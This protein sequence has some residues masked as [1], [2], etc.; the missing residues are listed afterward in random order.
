MGM[1]VFIPEAFSFIHARVPV[2]VP[3]FLCPL[4][5]GP[6]SVCVCVCV[7]VHLGLMYAFNHS[8]TGE[9]S[10]PCCSG[11]DLKFHATT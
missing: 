3:Y 6:T 5:A 1:C 4:R 7:R 11:A 2:P 9:K 8:S 10:D